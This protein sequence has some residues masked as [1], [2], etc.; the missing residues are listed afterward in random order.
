MAIT[1]VKRLTFLISGYRFHRYCYTLQHLSDITLS[2]FTYFT[3]CVTCE[4][5]QKCGKQT[6]WTIGTLITVYC[7]H[8]LGLIIAITSDPYSFVTRSVLL[9]TAAHK[10]VNR[11]IQGTPKYSIYKSCSKW[12]PLRAVINRVVVINSKQ[13]NEK[14]RG[15]FSALGVCRVYEI[16]SKNTQGTSLYKHIHGI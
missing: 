4:G 11:L 13:L 9:H 16:C 15:L 10:S 1:I 14:I 7:C 6:D 3:H 12:N 5:W 8:L 2:P